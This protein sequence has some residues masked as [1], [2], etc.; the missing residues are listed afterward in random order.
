MEDNTIILISSE[1]IIFF[2]WL[3]SVSPVKLEILL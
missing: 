2:G 1:I 3:T